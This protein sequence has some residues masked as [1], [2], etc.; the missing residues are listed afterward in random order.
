MQGPLSSHLQLV[1]T[2]KAVWNNLAV[3][4][5]GADEGLHDMFPRF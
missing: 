1:L 4:I 2:N 3:R 5:K